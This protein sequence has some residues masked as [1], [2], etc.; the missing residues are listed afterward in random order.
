[1]PELHAVDL[2]SA[3]LKTKESAKH[4]L[5]SRTDSHWNAYG[6]YIASMEIVRALQKRHAEMK[7]FTIRDLEIQE[8]NGQGGDIAAMLSM[9]EVMED[10]EV[11]LSGTKIPTPIPFNPVY[12]SEKGKEPIGFTISN[13]KLPKLLMLQDSFG[14]AL[15]PSLSAC[16]SRSV[17][18][19]T[20]SI[21][22]EV[23]E[24]EKPDIVVLEIV[25]RNLDHLL[26]DNLYKR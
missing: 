2:R 16:F 18:L 7:P 23:I 26:G 19:W 9:S 25:E 12:A 15:I 3:L 20:H 21:D 1:M 22:R 8:L 13:S 10:T 14:S 4:L 17:F 11:R 6:G 24:K 5:Y